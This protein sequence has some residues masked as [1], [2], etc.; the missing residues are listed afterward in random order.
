MKVKLLGFMLVIFGLWPIAATS[1]PE[2]EG[3]TVQGYLVDQVST[4]KLMESDDPIGVAKRLTKKQLLSPE[5]AESGYCVL[6]KEGE[7]GFHCITLHDKWIDVAKK[8]I[9]ASSKDAGFKVEVS[10]N[11]ERRKA[12]EITSLKE[13]E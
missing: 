7:G 8:I 11:Q 13:I 5:A 3:R 12:L 4:D 6:A 9:S 10:G 1:A 2:L